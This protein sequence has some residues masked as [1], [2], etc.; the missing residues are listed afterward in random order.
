[1]LQGLEPCVG[2][3]LPEIRILWLYEGSDPQQDGFPS[4]EPENEEAQDLTSR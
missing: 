2:G 4:F 3:E 1:M